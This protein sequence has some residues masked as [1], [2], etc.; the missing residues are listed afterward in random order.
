MKNK[1]YR[2]DIIPGIVLACF[3]TAYLCMI[4]KIKA[5]TGLGSTPLTN[6][7]VPYLWGGVLLFLSLWLIVRGI[8][9]YRRFKAEG[10]VVEKTSAKSVISDKREVVASFIALALY[11][12][13]MEA[14]GFVI[15]TI[16]YT[17]AQILI[18]TPREKWKKN[19]LPAAIVA[20]ITGCVLYYIF[21]MLLNVLL[22]SGILAAF[23]L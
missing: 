18:L 10:G 1:Q 2:Q 17:F 19:Y 15:T 16:L 13:L 8:L 20:V 6:H 23:N 7:F 3:S 22:P 21:K 11:V 14:L 9:K 12:G 5:F 4:P